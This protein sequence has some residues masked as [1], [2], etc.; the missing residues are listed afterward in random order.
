MFTEVITQK[1]TTLLE[2]SKSFLPLAE[3]QLQM[4][5]ENILTLQ[6]RRLTMLVE[7]DQES[8]SKQKQEIKK[9]ILNIQSATKVS[10]LTY[11]RN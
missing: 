11:L 1:E 5:L 9:Q 4:E 10:L 6:K 2:K 7:N 8:I 3:Q